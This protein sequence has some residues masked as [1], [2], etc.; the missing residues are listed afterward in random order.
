MDFY[1]YQ[2]PVGKISIACEDDYIVKVKLSDTLEHAVRKETPLIQEAYRQLTEYFEGKRT[3]FELPLK[4]KGTP[5]QQAVWN[6]LCRISYGKTKSYK[7]IAEM[8]GNPKACRAVGMANR[9]NPVMI[10]IPCHRV[11]GAD[12]SLTG[13][14]CGTEVKKQLL[15]LE[16]LFFPHL[17]T[18]KVI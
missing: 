11:I 16:N 7:E 14:A 17:M 3:H 4:P 6:A 5:F 9:R 8:V 15:A 10:I 2:T 12:G 13:Y 18:E 1:T